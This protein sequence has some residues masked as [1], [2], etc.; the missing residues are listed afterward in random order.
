MK[1]LLVPLAL[2]P[3]V[4]I[5]SLPV[6]MAQADSWWQTA[7]KNGVGFVFFLLFLGIT[8][9]TYNREKKAEAARVLRDNSANGERLAMQTEI[10]DLNKQ[11]L[12]SAK[13]HSK[14]LER[15]IKDGNKAQA[16]IG[17]EMKNLAR[18]VNC[19]ISHKS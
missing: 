4:F 13:D 16:D 3:S 15:L 5:S 8:F 1:D 18:K 19:P 11:Q 12:D 6:D 14:N 2:I 10:R 17:A 9:A 7:Q